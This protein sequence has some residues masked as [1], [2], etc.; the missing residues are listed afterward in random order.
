MTL[1][2]LAMINTE[3]NRASISSTKLESA[4]ALVF[5]RDDCPKCRQNFLTYY[6]KS[7]VDDHYV[8]INTNNA[9]NAKLAQHYHVEKVPTIIV[10]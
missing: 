9:S 7:L 8:L 4:H 6:L 1:F 2:V 10:K 5:Y 3:K